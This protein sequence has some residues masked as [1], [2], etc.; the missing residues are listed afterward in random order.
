M[1]DKKFPFTSQWFQSL[2]KCRI[3]L[4]NFLMGFYIIAPCMEMLHIK[5]SLRRW[6]QK[7]YMIH[8]HCVSNLHDSMEKMLISWKAVASSFS[9]YWKRRTGHIDQ[10]W[11]YN[12]IIKNGWSRIASFG[13]VWMPS[14]YPR[15]ACVYISMHDW[16]HYNQSLLLRLCYVKLM[17]LWWIYL[18]ITNLISWGCV[19]NI[20]HDIDWV[21]TII[22][23]TP[24]A[25]CH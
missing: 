18:S 6:S 13:M 8:T 25:M 5:R 11:P 7:T 22:R 2:F 15:N 17:N 19:H 23:S 20:L 1:M 3:D 21:S 24:T 10:W 16:M 9:R 4:L 14:N 12:H